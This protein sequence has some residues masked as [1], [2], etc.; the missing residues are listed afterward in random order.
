MADFKRYTAIDR[1]IKNIVDTDNRIRITGTVLS[2]EGNKENVI[3]IDDSSSSI[4][5][6][7]TEKPDISIGDKVRVFALRQGSEF[8]GEII[9]K[10][11]NDFDMNSYVKTRKLFNN[12][13]TIND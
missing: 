10:L 6:H 7:F 13:L 12:Y 2:I 9:Q 3:V 1:E 4:D 11:G 5:I 8:K